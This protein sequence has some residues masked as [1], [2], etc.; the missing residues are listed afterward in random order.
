MVHFRVPH[1]QDILRILF[2][3]GLVAVFALELIA[4]CAV[5]CVAA[6]AVAWPG[7]AVCAAQIS[8]VSNPAAGMQLA[9]VKLKGC[10]NNALATNVVHLVKCNKLCCCYCYCL[11][12]KFRIKANDS[13]DRVKF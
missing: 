7:A 1:T 12:L 10:M 6:S 3:V 2:V 8:A 13:A 5:R 4:A 9:A 11:S